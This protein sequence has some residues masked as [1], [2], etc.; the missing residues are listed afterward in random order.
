MVRVM[1]QRSRTPVQADR[2]T[3]AVVPS[4]RFEALFRAHFSEIYAYARSR[5]GPDEGEDVAAECFQAAAVVFE[6]GRGD[7]VTI[8]WLM[9]VA[10]NKVID[11]WRRAST[12]RARLHLVAVDDRDSDEIAELVARSA[13][14]DGVLAALDQL[15]Q[16]HRALLVMHHVDGLTAS[17]IGAR[18]GISVA[19]VNSALARARKA[20]RRS[21]DPP[22]IDHD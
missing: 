21:Y 18:L 14:R 3:V 15:T 20:F 16:R 4:A 7:E 11:R 5:L 19:N 8:R 2:P 13:R 6:S 1:F 10:H 17:E 12:R 9:A 22:E